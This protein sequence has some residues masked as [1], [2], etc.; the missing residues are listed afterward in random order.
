MQELIANRLVEP[1]RGEGPPRHNWNQAIDNDSGLTQV[2]A[3]LTCVSPANFKPIDPEKVLQ[4]KRKQQE[5]A[6]SFLRKN[7]DISSSTCTRTT[8]AARNSLSPR[9]QTEQPNE[10]RALV[11]LCRGVVQE[12]ELAKVEEWLRVASDAQRKKYAA[13][14]ASLRQSFLAAQD[15]IWREN[16]RAASEA[17]M[18]SRTG[19]KALKAGRDA[20]VASSL[21]FSLS[22]SQTSGGSYRLPGLSQGLSLTQDPQAEKV[23]NYL[24]LI[25]AQHR[26]MRLLISRVKDSYGTHPADPSGVISLCGLRMEAEA[27]NISL[28]I[29]STRTL[30]ELAH[31][32]IVPIVTSGALAAQ[33]KCIEVTRSCPRQNEAYVSVS[34]LLHLVNSDAFRT[35]KGLPSVLL[36]RTTAAGSDERGWSWLP[37]PRDCR[38]C[39][40]TAQRVSF[41]IDSA[42]G[43]QAAQELGRHAK[44]FAHAAGGLAHTRNMGVNG[45]YEPLL[46]DQAWRRLRQRARGVRSLQLERA[47]LRLQ[48]ADVGAGDVTADADSSLHVHAHANAFSGLPHTDTAQQPRPC[49]SVHLLRAPRPYS[50]AAAARLLTGNG[51]RPLT[52][53]SLPHPQ[54]S[55][56]GA[57]EAEGDAMGCSEG[58]GGLQRWEKGSLGTL[59]TVLGDAGL[60]HHDDREVRS[61]PYCPARRCA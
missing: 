19:S 4:E 61:L 59:L 53:Y 12:E 26:A 22:S 18:Q 8:E 58:H 56:D 27:G 1:A 30:L 2:H 52:R 14:F 45:Q 20:S 39:R 7:K 32:C 37:A 31:C 33:D 16:V 50:V 21:S 10:Q 51:G 41:A 54:A 55:W 11:D 48:A 25:A 44:S 9:L 17:S 28:P 46:L 3:T 6:I 49:Q 42:I 15:S 13:L 38:D 29:T 5:R 57:G 40:D 23:G 60:L 35:F 24:Q 43:K 34:K 47:V 36:S